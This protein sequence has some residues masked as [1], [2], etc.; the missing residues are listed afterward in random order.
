MEETEPRR[1]VLLSSFHLNGHTLGFYSQTQKLDPPS[2]EQKT[3]PGK[4]LLLSAF[5]LNGHF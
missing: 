5:H 4:V 1:K 3:K 2:T